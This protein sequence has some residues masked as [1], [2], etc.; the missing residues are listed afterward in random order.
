MTTQDHVHIST[1]LS[2]SPEFSPTNEFKAQI[3][4]PQTSI[5]VSINRAKS[6]KLLVNRLLSGGNPVVFLDYDLTLIVTDAERTTLIGMLGKPVYYVDLDHVDDGSDHTTYVKTMFFSQ[7][8]D[9][10]EFDPK[11]ARWTVHVML[12]D[13]D[14]V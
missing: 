2:G 14:T 10:K 8:G 5:E 7:M 9:H 11:R 4:A 3:L 6:G 13:D 1:T 12:I